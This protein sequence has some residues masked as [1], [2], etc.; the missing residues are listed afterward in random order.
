MERDKIRTGHIL[1]VINPND[2]LISKQVDG[3]CSVVIVKKYNTT[4]HVEICTRS[5]RGLMMTTGITR[6]IRY[7]DLKKRTTQDATKGTQWW[8]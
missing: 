1:E 8:T 4:C 2:Y 6:N 3:R 7:K 5:A